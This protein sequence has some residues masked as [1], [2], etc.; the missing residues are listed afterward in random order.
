MPRDLVMAALYHL[1][2]GGWVMLPLAAVSLWMW[3]LILR[4]AWAFHSLKR[5]E[6][7]AQH[8]NA[9]AS[10]PSW[11]RAVLDGFTANRTDNDALNRKLIQTLADKEL[12]GSER[13]I[14][15]ILLLAGIAPLLGLLGTVGGMIATFDSILQFG[16]G[17]ARALSAGISAALITTQ[18]GLVV[19]V[20]GLLAGTILKRRAH[21][22]RAR[23][24]CFCITVQDTDAPLEA[25]A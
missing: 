4:K 14:D 19:A 6:R 22:L 3:T 20:P 15:T 13:G 9:H 7:A 23:A 25:Q 5:K 21:N 1:Q 8:D 11:Q 16:T 17:N 10:M 2:G 24:E 18:S 12:A